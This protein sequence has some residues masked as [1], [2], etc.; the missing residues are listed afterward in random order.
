M[1]LSSF[2]EKKIILIDIQFDLKIFLNRKKHIITA[3][4]VFLEYL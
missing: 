4:I 1:F 3:I 2:V